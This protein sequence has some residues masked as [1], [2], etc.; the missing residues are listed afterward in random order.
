MI[1]QFDDLNIVERAEDYDSYFGAMELK[2]SQK[3]DRIFVAKRIEDEFLFFI[4]YFMTLAE[5]DLDTYEAAKELKTRYGQIIKEELGEYD[6]PLAGEIENEDF[7]EWY[8][9]MFANNAYNSTIR[10]LKDAW[11]FSLDRA[12][13][14]GENEANTIHNYKD[15]REMLSLGY[16]RKQW[17]DIQ[18]NKE[19]ETH[20]EVGGAVIPID[21]LFVVG[22]SIMRYPKDMM[23][24]PEP[25]E[26]V[27]CRCSIRWVR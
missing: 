18:D 26:I 27:N 19:R 16:T 4:S 14:N 23:Y 22:N 13:L 11:Y 7:S 3:R 9:L 15:Y 17:I 6:T 24:S 8:A 10:H 25:Q 21:S 2:K 20:R 5:K 12:K 1:L